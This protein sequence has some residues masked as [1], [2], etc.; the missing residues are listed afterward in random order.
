MG[1]NATPIPFPRMGGSPDSIAEGSCTP[2]SV[3]CGRG[4]LS[5]FWVAR[6]PGTAGVA[7]GQVRVLGAMKPKVWK[8]VDVTMGI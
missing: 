4:S 7:S 2:R 3:H 5:S 8:D 1:H 6:A